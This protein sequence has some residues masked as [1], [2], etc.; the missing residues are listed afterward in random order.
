MTVDLKNSQAVVTPAEGKGFDPSQIPKAVRNAGFEPGE[1]HVTAMGILST[2]EGL[3]ALEMTGAV[4]RFVLA[5]GPK[6][7]ELS[8]EPDL[9]SQRVRVTGKLHPSHADKPPGLT[10]E[11]WAPAF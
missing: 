3:L 10:V 8:Q 7:D 9:L 2:A 11:T 1:I 5:G 6:V 4:K